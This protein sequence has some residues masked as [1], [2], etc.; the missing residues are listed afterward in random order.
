[1]KE[2]KSEV[3][4]VGGGV[5]GCMAALAAARNGSD[6]IIIER[7]G[8]LGGVATN[9][10]VGPSQTFHAGEEQ[11]IKGFGQELVERMVKRNA[12]PGH[13]YDM[14]GFVSTLTPFNSEELKVVLEEM[15]LESNVK[16]MYHS[17][18]HNIEKNNDLIKSVIVSNRSDEYKV[19][20]NVFIDCSG[21]ADLVYLAD[22]PYQLGRKKDNKVQP[23]SLMFKMGGVNFEPLRKAIKNNPDD[24]VLSKDRDGKKAWE[25]PY[26]AVN[27]YFSK[28]QEAK[29]KGDFNVPRDRVLFFEQPSPGVITVNMT[30]VVDKNPVNGKDLGE[31]EVESRRQVINTINFLKNYLPGFDASYLIAI[32]PQIGI[33]ESRR[34]VGDYVLTGK[35]II[36]KAR[37]DN[38]ISRG[39]YPIDIHSPDGEEMEVQSLEDGEWYH[40]PRGCLITS[41]IPNLLVAG[42]NISTTHEAHASTRIQPSS[43]ALGQAA[44]TNAA[45]SVKLKKF[46]LEVDVQKLQDNLRKDNAIV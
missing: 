20:G 43:M 38:A 3:V 28:V 2:I 34:L 8:F 41:E 19:E 30:R 29:A 21:D 13:I 40:I 42:R 35:E 24:F 17:T 14:I 23:M 11:I 16:I 44:G 10:L 36:Q 6:V 31:A 37:F 12:S 45:L 33:R 7:Y 4:V 46:P 18:M 22:G 1:M 15:L 39:A 27:G 9:A 32:A 25:F 26:V 5:A